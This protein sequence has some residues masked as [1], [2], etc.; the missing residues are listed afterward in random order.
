MDQNSVNRKKLFVVSPLSPK[1]LTHAVNSVDQCYSCGDT[2]DRTLAG[3]K[4]N[5]R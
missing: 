2:T 3:F 4:K 5:P 1:H